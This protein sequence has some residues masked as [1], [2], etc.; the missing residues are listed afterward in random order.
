MLPTRRRGWWRRRQSRRTLACRRRLGSSAA[1]GHLEV[2]AAPGHA[3]TAPRAPRP[4]CAGRRRPR[5]T[6]ACGRRRGASRGSA[7]AAASSARSASSTCSA[8]SHSRG[9]SVARQLMPA[10]SPRRAWTA[11]KGGVGR[12]A[13]RRGL[14]RQLRRAL[15]VGCAERFQGARG[16]HAA[17]RSHRRR[18]RAAQQ[19][20]LCARGRTRAVR[21]Q[22]EAGSQRRT[23]A[24]GARGGCPCC[25]RSQ[26]LA[27]PRPATV[28][29]G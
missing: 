28:V 8:A 5:A 23:P 24:P 18:L 15:A 25:R 12:R 7:A 20:H 4:R 2:D 11:T 27:T 16:S 21:A 19:N 10:R 29:A 1:L 17:R 13:R 26:L 14:V 22:A 3:A 9:R 6:A